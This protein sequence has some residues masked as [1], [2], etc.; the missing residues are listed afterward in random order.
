M[1]RAMAY[2]IASAPERLQQRDHVAA[3]VAL[4]AALL[5][6]AIALVVL[7]PCGDW[8]GRRW[9]RLDLALALV[10]ALLAPALAVAAARDAIRLLGGC[11]PESRY[12]RQLR[13]LL[14][15]AV[16]VVALWVAALLL[17]WWVSVQIARLA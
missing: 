11:D 15:G 13:W 4:A 10:A 14:R 6:A 2:A 3:R 7:T 5:G 1:L 9:E 12:A 8:F 17:L 16:G